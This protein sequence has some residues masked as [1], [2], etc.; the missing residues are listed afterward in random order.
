MLLS[1]SMYY[2]IIRCN[3]FFGLVQKMEMCYIFGII[4]VNFVCIIFIL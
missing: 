4:I 3:G 2:D 1:I